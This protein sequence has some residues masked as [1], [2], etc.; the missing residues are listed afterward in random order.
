MAKATD[1]HVRNREYPTPPPGFRHRSKVQ[2]G[3]TRRQSLLTTRPE[4]DRLP[5]ARGLVQ[6][7]AHHNLVYRQIALGERLS[8]DAREHQYELAAHEIARHIEDA[9][10]SRVA[11]FRMADRYANWERAMQGIGA[12][13][14][15][16]IVVF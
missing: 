9:T 14:F 5:A 7:Y 8:M 2:R 6:C 11:H 16:G 3:S 10:T 12:L 15:A 4:S 1:A 13:S